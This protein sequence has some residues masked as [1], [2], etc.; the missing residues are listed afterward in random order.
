MVLVTLIATCCLTGPE[1]LQAKSM[2]DK[3]KTKITSANSLKAAI[4][5]KFD[6]KPDTIS[7]NEKLLINVRGSTSFELLSLDD[8]STL[9]VLW[10]NKRRILL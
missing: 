2:F 4:E 7:L 5:L 9:S 1:Q 8:K 3:M 10:Q 6:G